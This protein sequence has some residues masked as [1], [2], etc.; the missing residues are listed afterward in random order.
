[1]LEI[2][3]AKEELQYHIDNLRSTRNINATNAKILSILHNHPCPLK[4]ANDLQ[5]MQYNNNIDPLYSAKHDYA[6]KKIIDALIYNLGPHASIKSE[7]KVSNGKFDI[8]IFYDKII[9]KYHKKIICVEIKSGKSIDLFQIERYLY[10]CDLLVIVRVPTQDVTIIHHTNI[11]NELKAGI[12]SAIQKISQLN[13]SDPLKVQGE[14][15]RGC[16]ATCEFKKQNNNN[17]TK[18]SMADL[19]D[20]FKDVNAV[21]DSTISLLKNELADFL[22]IPEPDLDSA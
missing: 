18:A 6:K 14:W 20:F 21:V 16:T 11:V 22:K 2:D 3:D 10:E 4:C 13:A 15:C 7:H 9:L 12:L 5:N 1:M 17:N 19:E 8:A